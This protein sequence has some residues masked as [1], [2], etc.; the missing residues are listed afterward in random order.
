MGNATSWGEYYYNG[1]EGGGW[2]GL[3]E[4]VLLTTIDTNLILYND[5][6]YSGK[7][8]ERHATSIFHGESILSD[9]IFNLIFFG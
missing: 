6:L 3:E 8:R 9:Q 2:E 1:V 4:L 7:R 5:G